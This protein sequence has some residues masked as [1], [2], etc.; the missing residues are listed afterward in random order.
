MSELFSEAERIA[1]S[2]PFELLKANGIFL[3]RVR[4]NPEAPRYFL[5]YGDWARVSPAEIFHFLP[6]DSSRD[7]ELYVDFP[8]CPTICNFCA[9][10][11]VRPGNYGE[12]ADYIKSLKVEISLLKNLYFDR[13]YAV[14]TMELGG[15]TPTFLPLDLLTDALMTILDAFPFKPGGEHSFETTPEAILD[16]DGPAK[17]EF[18]RR[19]AGFD[20]ISIGAQSFSNKVLAASN[21]SHDSL[22]IRDAF[23]AARSLGFER[24]NLDLLLGLLDQTLPDFIESVVKSIELGADIVEI[25]AMR[26]FDTKKPVP[27]TR[28]YVEQPSRFLSERDL[29]IG[30]IAADLVLR[31]AGYTSHNGRTYQKQDSNK[32]YY[33]D[34]YKGNFQGK[35]ILGIGRKSFSRIHNW[36]YANYSNLD[37]YGSALEGGRL[38][39]AAGCKLDDRALLASRLTGAL[40]M[41]DVLNWDLIG[42]DFDLTLRDEFDCILRAFVNCGLMTGSGTGSFEKTSIGFFFVEEMLKAVYDLGVTPFNAATP[43][44][45]KPQRASVNN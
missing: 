11:P 40:Q 28:R 3:D 39:I 33:S 20:R 15:G 17:A 24:I 35:N 31:R 1:D 44:L 7:T 2:I 4:D 19:T 14:E 21:R 5:A 32:E 6:C 41:S 34:Y 38:P 43:F 22:Q 42:E 23:Q 10:Y 26:Y 8:F 29:L 27:L 25:Y 18:L 30:K 9:F 36:Q 13:G 16:A 37:K 12:M 45:G